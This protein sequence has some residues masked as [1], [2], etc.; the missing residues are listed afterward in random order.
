MSHN[1]T[2]KSLLSEKK[3]CEIV[4]ITRQQRR[5]LVQRGLIEP[6][7]EQGSSLN[8]CLRLAALVSLTNRLT[9]N[10]VSVAWPQLAE[11]LEGN[12]P[13]ER[14]DAVFDTALGR[15][16]IARDSDELRRLAVGAVTVRVIPLAERLSEVADAFRR[17]L[18]RSARPRDGLLGD[19]RLKE[20]PRTEST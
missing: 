7:T 8:E 2:R 6:S 14:L 19:R 10:E 17:G 3:I 20:T 13:L 15:L 5:A 12:L 9:P 16:D 1:R 4:G 11:A 18:M